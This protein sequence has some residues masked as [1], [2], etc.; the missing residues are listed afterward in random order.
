LSGERPVSVRELADRLKSVRSRIAEAAVRAG[1]DPGLV[2]L[3][4]VTKG[5]GV[6]QMAAAAAAGV[7]DVG[8]NYVQEALAKRQALGELARDLRWHIIGS[9]QRNKVRFVVDLAH[10]IHS[11][12][13]V[14]LVEALQH[15]ASETGRAPE[16]LVQVNAG[17]GAPPGGVAAEEAGELVSVLASA[18][19]LRV[20]GLMTIAPWVSDPEQA[21]PAFAR[22]RGLRDRLAEEF[23]GLDLADLSMGMSGDFEV[24]VEEGATLVRVGT[25]LFGPRPPRGG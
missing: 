13:R 18:G 12:D 22:L 1:R 16:V 7:T 19:D 6:E 21:R 8:E 15:R 2:R 5:V 10:M 9:V 17:P 14:A 4:A 24:A 20:R 25:A 11:V 3:V 23:P